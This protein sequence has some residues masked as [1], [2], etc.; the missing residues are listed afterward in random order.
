MRSQLAH[1]QT[2]I[3]VGVETQQLEKPGNPEPPGRLPVADK[4]EV[5][6]VI[7]VFNQWAY[8]AACL[9]SLADTDCRTPF[10]VI[11]VDDQSS[12]ETAE[13]LATVEGLISI[14]NKKNLG[15]IGSCNRGSE[16]AKGKYIVLLN[17]DTQVLDGWLD[18]YS[19][20]SNDFRIP[21]WP[22]PA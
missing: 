6:I 20:H 14:H 1:H 17:N 9:R 10:E 12:D 21:A 2:F 19:I 13:R 4:P 18:T 16:R 7:P 8:T 22:A 15:F 3:P 5:T 11:I